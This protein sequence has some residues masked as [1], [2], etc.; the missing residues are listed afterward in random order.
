MAEIEQP[1]QSGKTA[2]TDDL[3]ARLKD[4]TDNP[5]ASIRTEMERSPQTTWLSCFKTLITLL[6]TEI[7]AGGIIEPEKK[8]EIERKLEAL[9]GK[10]DGINDPNPP[11]ED[12]EK[13]LAELRAITE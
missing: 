9:I 10:I 2:E 7:Q 5:K 3:M 6:T 13:L 1:K 12:K 8:A 4:I 11:N